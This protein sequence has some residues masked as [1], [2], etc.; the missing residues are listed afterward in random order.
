METKS[1]YLY[2]MCY[3]F[4]ILPMIGFLLGSYGWLLPVLMIFGL[5]P[6]LDYVY[7]DERSVIE[8]NQ[9]REHELWYKN[10]CLSFVPYALIIMII[11]L[12]L[13][14]VYKPSNLQLMAFGMTSGLTFGSLSI[15]MSHELLHKR[16]LIERIAARVLL[17]I[18]FYGQF[19][20][21]HVRNH[22]KHAATKE[23]P[24]SGRY[25]E[26]IYHFIPRSI[27][28]SWCSALLAEEKRLKKK[29]RSFW[30]YTNEFYWIITTPVIILLTA[31]FIAGLTGIYFILYQSVITVIIV[32]MVNYMG[33]YGLERKKLPNGQYE[34]ISPQHSWN[35]THV[36]SNQLLLNLQRHSDHHVHGGR[37][38]QYIQ[39]ISDAPQYPTGYPGLALIVFIPP[40]WRHIIHKRIKRS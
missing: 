26:S 23:D 29:N 2:L 25:N 22:H 28:Q 36:V 12:W 39:S 15:N 7:T 14:D 32:E 34:P 31:Y 18:F 3:I 20:I 30:H 19:Y 33:H 8:I 6:I 40:L 37:R 21:E 38:Y 11:S 27:Y 16:S 4:A 35:C 10:V 9:S 24:T 1:R 13:V 5:I 17:G